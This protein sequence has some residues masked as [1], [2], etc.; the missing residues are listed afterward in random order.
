MPWTLIMADFLDKGKHWD[1]KEVATVLRNA[2]AE[3]DNLKKE[4]QGLSDAELSELFASVGWVEKDNNLKDLGF[5]D[6][7]RA[8]E[9]K[10][11]EKN[12][13]TNTV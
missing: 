9:M 3:I 10:L 1:S 11:R 8:I 7:A 4:W 2:Q 5:Y 13:G 6:H 12:S